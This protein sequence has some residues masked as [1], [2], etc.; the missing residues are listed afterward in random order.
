MVANSKR[1]GKRLRV[2]SGIALQ[3][4]FVRHLVPEFEEHTGT[5]LEII[6]EPTTVIMKRIAA[7]ERADV[8]VAIDNSL[9]RLEEEGVILPE[10]RR[11]IA[12][13]V[14]GIG[15]R[16]G[17]PRPDISDV[18]RF[19][20]ALVEA[21]GVAYSLAGASGIYFARLAEELGIAGDIKGVTIPAGLTAEKLVTGE[22]ELAVQQ[23]SEL[24]S[25]DGTDV[26]G[27]FPDDVQ[28]TTHFS[29]AQFKEA[30][31]P[32]DA[33]G[34]LASLVTENAHEAYSE[35]GLVSRLDPAA[36]S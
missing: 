35:G 1:T 30:A 14:L 15:V 13:A 17:R 2:M 4:A 23:I 18:E 20:Q 12:D 24:I 8:I 33:A 32:E 7:G 31:N 36:W 6:W 5:E 28:A 27:P 29:A 25:V 21:D 9:D 11:K 34:F 26:V 16:A 3:V 22:A 10:S 19:K